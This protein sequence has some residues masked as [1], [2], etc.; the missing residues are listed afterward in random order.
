MAVKVTKNGKIVIRN[1]K[2]RDRQYN[3]HKEKEQKEKQ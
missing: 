2:S 1:R 3:D